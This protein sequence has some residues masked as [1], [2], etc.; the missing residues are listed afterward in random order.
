MADEGNGGLETL[1][2][3]AGRRVA[4]A[5]EEIRQARGDRKCAVLLVGKGNNGGD[6]LVAARLLHA[7]DWN[8]QVVLVCLPHDL[9]EL[10]KSMFALLPEAIRQSA[11]IAE[12]N[13]QHIDTKD[14]IIID[15]LLGTGFNGQMPREPLASLIRQ[16]NASHRPILA[17]DIPSGL[18]GETGEAEL[19][20]QATATVCLC[21][22]KT[23]LLVNQGI[24]SAGRLIPA[25][26]PGQE[27]LAGLPHGPAVFGKAEARELVPQIAFDAHK[28]QRGM[29]SVLGGSRQYGGAPLLSGTAALHAGAGL[30]QV[31][32][33]QNCEVFCAAPQALI[34]QRLPDDGAGHFTATALPALQTGLARSAAIAVGPGMTSHPDILPVL[35]EVLGMDKPLVLDAD[36][37]NLLATCPALLHPK[38]AAEIVLTPHTGEFARL[39]KAFDL[40]TTGDR[41]Q[42]ALALAQRTSCV[43]VLKGARTIVASPDGSFSYNLSGCPALATAGSG[44]ILT[45]VIAALLANGLPSYDAARL[46]VWLHGAA[47]ERATRPGS[48]VGIIADDLPRLIAT[49]LAELY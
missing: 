49:T 35:A 29:V 5:A 12:K 11:V 25:P 44:D 23:G 20:I 2:C 42:D 26:L 38:H 31:L 39:Q 32:L 13:L 43:V 45:G 34:V 28:F 33:P 24:A 22:V 40:T 3:L 6:S 14:T 21:A 41:A 7:D 47:A 30:V 1:M 10:P 19:C 17:I 48:P 8:L 18:N 9:S 16:A 37:L 27:L 46:G 36:A 15:G 4:E